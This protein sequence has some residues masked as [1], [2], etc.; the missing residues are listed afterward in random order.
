MSNSGIKIFAPACVSMHSFGMPNLSIAMDN[1]GNE[2]IAHIDEKN[3]YATIDLY[4][5]EKDDKNNTKEIVLDIANAF[6]KYI[7][8]N[9]GIR[10]EILNKIPFDSGLG[11]LESSVTGSIVAINDILKSHLDKQEIFK[12][13]IE[14]IQDYNIEINPSNIAAN[15]FGGIILYNKNTNNPIQKIYSPYGINF[16]LILMKREINNGTFDSLDPI[17]LLDQSSNIA[18]LIKGLMISDLDLIADALK[19]NE[20][21][22]FFT[23]KIFE[24]IKRISYKND[25]YSVGFSHLGE[26]IIIMNPNSLIEDKNSKELEKYLKNN[27]EKF[28]I[29]TAKLNLNG[30]YKY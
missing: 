21:E 5:K 1:P 27:G 30:L 15:L 17:H 3:I 7:N 18:L 9:K 26:S 2:I 16:S 14:K 6:L 24:E 10:F 11:Q 13:L 8:S 12:F 4:S 29:L 19:N 25:V 28:K 22:R 23:N 20:L